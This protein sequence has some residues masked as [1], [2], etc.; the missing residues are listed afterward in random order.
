MSTA[1]YSITSAIVAILGAAPAV[2]PT[3]YRARDRQVPKQETTAINVQWDG[4]APHAGAIFGAPVDW[5]S[6]FT[7]ECYARS[8]AAAADQAIDP[9]LSAVYDRLAA[10]TT[11]GDLVDDVGV[12][13]IEAEYSAEGDRTGWVR[14][15]YTIQHR[16]NNS[17]LEQP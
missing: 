9:L 2:S 14:M 1:F 16:T 17:T 4:A 11:L 7:V 5:I 3:I 10:D 15:T 6:K 8:A 12:P 13:F